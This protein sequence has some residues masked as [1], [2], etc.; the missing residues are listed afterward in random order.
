LGDPSSGTDQPSLRRLTRATATASSDITSGWADLAD[1]VSFVGF[2]SLFELI[3]RQVR[4]LE[5]T[6][7]RRGCRQSPK[8]SG[9]D[10][11]EVVP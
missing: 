7:T 3:R 9:L 8:V 1:T 2:D 4:Q 6:G 11:I 5:T 10:R